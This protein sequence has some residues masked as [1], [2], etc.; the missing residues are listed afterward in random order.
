MSVRLDQLHM[1]IADEEAPT[2]GVELQ[3]EKL[4]RDSRSAA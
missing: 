3:G 1:Q 2:A 4:T